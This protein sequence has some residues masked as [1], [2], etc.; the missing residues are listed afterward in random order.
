MMTKEPIPLSSVKKNQAVKVSVI[1]AGPALGQRLNA[2]GLYP[3]RELTVI[4]N[5]D[6]SLMIRLERERLVLGRTVGDH[7]LVTPVAKLRGDEP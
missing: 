6:G 3:G 4:R 2:M 1:H 5:D 7:I